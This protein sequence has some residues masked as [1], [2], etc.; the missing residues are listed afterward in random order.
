MRRRLIAIALV[1]ITLVAGYFL[2][3]RDSS[4][5]A[6]KS[7]SVTGVRGPDAVRIRAALA[8]SAS[9]M[10]TLHVRY[11]ALE[12]AVR[13]FPI[14]KSIEAKPSF[15]NGLAV[16]VVLRRP[17]IVIDAGGRRIAADG[18]GM[19][20]GPVGEGAGARAAGP[21]GMGV[22]AGTPV[23]R[24]AEPPGGKRLSGDLL[25]QAAVLSGLPKALRPYYEDSSVVQGGVTVSLKNGPEIRFGDSSDVP[26]KWA[27]AVRVLS[28][29]RVRGAGY[30]DVSA[31][32]RPAVGGIVQPSGSAAAPSAPAGA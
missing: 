20:L 9:G 31:S 15:P 11:D 4:L 29:P 7:L 14:V 1:A 27:A 32:R 23:V 18:D 24:A 12:Q 26:A 5:V 21:H 25:M 22:D 10:T 8:R 3:L 6:V 2:W 16:Q 13:P 17:A 28:D 19:L 30:V